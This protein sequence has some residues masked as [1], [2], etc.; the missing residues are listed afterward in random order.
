MISGL[1]VMG[2]S[3][4]SCA[5]VTSEDK[6]EAIDVLEAVGIMVGG[7]NG[8]FNPDQSVTR[9]EMTVVMFNLMEHNVASCKDTI[10]GGEKAVTTAQAAPT[11]D[12]G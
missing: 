11:E 7:Q 4:A 9:N 3:A 1:M 5:D 8:D 6:V 2:A 10:Y 12:F